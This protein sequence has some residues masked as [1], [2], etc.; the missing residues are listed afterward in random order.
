MKRLCSVDPVLA[1]TDV[2]DVQN[3]VALTGYE[4]AQMK[5]FLRSQAEDPAT[6]E[7]A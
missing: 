4:S 3:D 7:V 2:C 1:E 5:R 6:R